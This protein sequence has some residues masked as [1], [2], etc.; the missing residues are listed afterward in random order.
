MARR[1]DSSPSDD[2][3]ASGS[4]DFVI[5]PSLAG[6]PAPSLAGGGGA[7]L[8][9]PGLAAPDDTATSGDFTPPA[10]DAGDP[11]RGAPQ[12]PSPMECRSRR[13]PSRSAVDRSPAYSPGGAMPTA[14]RSSLARTCGRRGRDGGSGGRGTLAAIAA[15][16]AS[17]AAAAPGHPARRGTAVATDRGVD[18]GR[19]RRTAPARWADLRHRRA[20]PRAAG[21]D[22]GCGYRQARAS[23]AAEELVER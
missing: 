11:A 12:S 1:G 5:Q 6:R 9:S 17:A 22:Q 19:R 21:R 4:D 10:A 14:R 23:R 20:D 3:D 7:R 13:P 8:A 16:S 15:A 2:E 18:V